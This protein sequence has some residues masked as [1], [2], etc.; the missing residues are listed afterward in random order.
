MDAE[1]PRQSPDDDLEMPLTESTDEGL[2]QLAVVLVMEGGILFVELMQ[3]G[4]QFVFLAALFHFDGDRDHRLG[5]RD[6]GQ[7]QPHVLAGQRV[8]GVRIAQLRDYADVARVQLRNLDPFFSETDAKMVQLFGR[9]ARRVP[10]VLPVLDAA[11]ED[12]KQRDVADVR[13]RDG[14]EDLRRQGPCVVAIAALRRADA[15]AGPDT[16]RRAC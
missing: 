10:H 6:L 13:L 5:E 4:R 16:A 11:R 15:H 12:A 8:V 9:L 14:L 3:P 7:H 2:G 1:L